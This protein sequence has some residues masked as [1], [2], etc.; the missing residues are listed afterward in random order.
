MKPGC[1]VT[2]IICNVSS[3]VHFQEECPMQEEKYFTVLLILVFF[4]KKTHCFQPLAKTFSSSFVKLF[5]SLV[6]IAVLLHYELCSQATTL[7]D[8]EKNRALLQLSLTTPTAPYI[9]VY[10]R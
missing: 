2:H 3:W 1:I 6:P 4:K 7:E 8:V 10:Y 5:K 9:A